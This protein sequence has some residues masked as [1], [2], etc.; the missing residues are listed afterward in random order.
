MQGGCAGLLRQAQGC[1]NHR[2][3]PSQAAGSGPGS[4]MSRAGPP[5]PPQACRLRLPCSHMVFPLYVCVQILSGHQ[6]YWVTHSRDLMSTITSVKTLSQ[7]HSHIRGCWVV[8]TLIH[9]FWGRRHNSAHNNY[10]PHF[11]SS[12]FPAGIDL[13]IKDVT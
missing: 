1:R 6:S 8:R 11:S 2:H 7:N 10:A 3:P 4:G 13:F 12:Q 9:K 5:E